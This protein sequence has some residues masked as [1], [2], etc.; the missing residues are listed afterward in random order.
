METKQEPREDFPIATLKFVE[1]KLQILRK[2]I[3]EK[4]AEIA[5]KEC[6]DT[7]EVYVV[8][9]EHARQAIRE[10]VGT[11]LWSYV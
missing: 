8:T 9:Q 4:A 5:K 11:A 7:A 3:M 10:V 2:R 1:S 6:S